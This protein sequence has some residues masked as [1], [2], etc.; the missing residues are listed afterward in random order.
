MIPWVSIS[1]IAA[2]CLLAGFTLGLEFERRRKR[3]RN[4][5]HVY[6]ID[7]SEIG[8]TQDETVL[9]MTC[10]CGSHIAVVTNAS[11]PFLEA[12]VR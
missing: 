5:Q 12:I 7:C 3:H 8:C 6:R 10:R 11:T 1:F 9:F 4:H 2:G